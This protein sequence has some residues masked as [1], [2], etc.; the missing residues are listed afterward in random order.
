M[1]SEVDNYSL[2]RPLL[3]FDNDDEFYFLQILMRK[4]DHGKNVTGTNNNNRLVKAY[5]VRSLE[6]F[7]F[8]E[9]EVKK[10]AQVFKARVTVNLNKRSYKKLAFHTLK[11]VTD[12][13]VNEEY[14][15]VNKAYTSVCGKYTTDKN[16]TWILDLDGADF[17]DVERMI[18]E[19]LP[20]CRGTEGNRHIA[21]IPTRSGLH[22]IT[23]PFAINDFNTLM[24]QKFNVNWTDHVELHKNNPT[25]LYCPEM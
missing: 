5:F 1:K 19:V 9:D 15:K 22:V 6:Y 14:D 7:D 16:K 21:S 23:R 17:K 24:Y 13:I 3:T 18:L 12:Q 25:N 4:K 20:L 2:I 10:L 11:K 8:I